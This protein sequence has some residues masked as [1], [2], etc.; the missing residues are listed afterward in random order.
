MMMNQSAGSG[1]FPIAKTS[2][3]SSQIRES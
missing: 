1:V 3:A 2:I